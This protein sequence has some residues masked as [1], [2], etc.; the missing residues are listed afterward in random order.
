MKASDVRQMKSL[1]L[2]YIGDA[3]YE[4]YVREQLLERGTIKPN[5]LHQAAIRYVSG[6]SQAKVILHWL[7]QDAFLTEEES[8]VV[9]RGRNAKSGSIPKNIN[10]QTYRYSTAFEAL[11]GYHYLLKNEQRLQELMTQAMDFLEEGSA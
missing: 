1:A 10:V 5:Q 2:A 6:K 11:I 4:V 3:I 8:R 7:E 9:I